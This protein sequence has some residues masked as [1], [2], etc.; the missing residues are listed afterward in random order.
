MIVV[1]SGGGDIIVPGALF[2]VVNK[3][4]TPPEKS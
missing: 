1:H 2:S 4:V 3:A